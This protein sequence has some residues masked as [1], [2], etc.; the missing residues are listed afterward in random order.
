MQEFRPKH[1]ILFLDDLR[2]IA[3]LI[4]VWAHVFIVGINDG[5]GVPMRVPPLKGLMFG[6]GSPT[7]NVNDHVNMFFIRTFDISTGQLGVL[8]F[9]LISGFV[10]L[11]TLDRSTPSTF[12]LRRF[13]RII[14]LNAL[15]TCLVAVFT[16]VMCF[17]TG[18]LNP[19]TP[20]SVILSSFLLHK[21]F[22]SILVPIPI[23]WT[24]EVEVVFYLIMAATAKIFGKLQ[25]RHLLMLSIFC[26]LANPLLGRI[27]NM[28]PSEMAFSVR[29][30]AAT[31]DLITYLFVGAVLYRGTTTGNLRK[32]VIFTAL[33]ASITLLTF[34]LYENKM[35]VTAQGY[36]IPSFI[37]AF[38]I[39]MA[40]FLFQPRTRLLKPLKFFGKISYPLYLVHTPLVWWV[41]WMLSTIGTNMYLAGIVATAVAIAAAWVLHVI[42]EV[43]IQAFGK[44]VTKSKALPAENI[45]AASDQSKGIV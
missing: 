39:F 18:T 13:F 4:V 29:H 11:M 25:F 27:A 28:V 23:L 30:T 34:H 8:I 19:Y 35:P 26:L 42:A 15:V 32:T 10:I 12:I 45:L 38:L 7:R 44:R 37:G 6:E 33:T 16:L 14:P 5:V 31:L 17:I 22:P 21:Y 43:P 20:A 24:L 40:F 36:N 3:V 41:M 1:R 9:F 2:G